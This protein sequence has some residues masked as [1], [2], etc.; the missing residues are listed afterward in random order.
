MNLTNAKLDIV[1]D[2]AKIKTLVCCFL[3]EAAIPLP[4]YL[5]AVPSKGGLHGPNTIGNLA[6]QDSW[7]EL[8]MEVLMGY[9]LIG[10]T[11]CGE[12]AARVIAI[13]ISP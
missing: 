1:I 12:H 13:D 4:G 3:E 11:R 5:V 2:L 6:C 9:V 10:R 7:Q 8:I